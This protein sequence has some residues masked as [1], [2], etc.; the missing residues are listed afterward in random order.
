MRGQ[1]GF[2]RDAR[3]LQLNDAR[4]NAASA[5]AQEQR[6]GIFGQR[7]GR[8]QLRARADPLAQGRQRFLPHGHGAALAAL[9]QHH[10]FGF[11]QAQPAARLV[12]R[13][14]LVAQVQSHQFRQAQ[15]AG[16]EQFEHGLVAQRGGFRGD[17]GGRAVQQ[18]LGLLHRQCL[19]QTARRLGRTHVRDGIA[20]QIGGRRPPL[21]ETAPGGQSARQA[22][23]TAALGVQARHELSDMAV[24]ELVQR[25]AGLVG[26][27]AQEVEF[28]PVAVQRVGR[29]AA[30]GFQMAQPGAHR[31]GQ[32]GVGRIAVLRGVLHC[33]LLGRPLGHVRLWVWPGSGG[34]VP[35]MPIG[36]R[37]PGTSFPFRA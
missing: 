2:L 24:G 1:S 31:I 11:V 15:A 3:Q 32:G 16:I 35:P 5:R 27:F 36:P 9:A 25:Q 30:V 28:P 21:V 37:T 19:G 17:A 7:R 22:A 6:G 10:H 26:E 8:G 23:R 4:G 13:G 18:G 20:G 34:A 33:V 14:P 12:I 29:V